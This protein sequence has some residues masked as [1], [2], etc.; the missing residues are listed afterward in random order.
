[1]K[2]KRFTY[3]NVSELDKKIAVEIYLKEK[4]EAIIEDRKLPL[5][6]ETVSNVD[7]VRER[8]KDLTQSVDT[9]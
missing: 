5:E 6:P 3:L 8:Y 4:R 2:T 9:V 1:M 7:K